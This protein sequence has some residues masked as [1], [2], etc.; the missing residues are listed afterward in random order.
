MLK[1][2][3]FLFRM[4]DEFLQNSSSLIEVLTAFF[5]IYLQIA[6]RHGDYILFGLIVLAVFWYIYLQEE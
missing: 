2:L 4:A 3:K 6:V 1:I 5:K